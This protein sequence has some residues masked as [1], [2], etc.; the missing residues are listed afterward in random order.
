MRYKTIKLFVGAAFLLVSCFV[1]EPFVPEFPVGEVEGYK[2]LYANDVDTSIEVEHAQPLQNP[3]KIYVFQHYL[4]VSEQLKGIHV[5]DN[6]NPVDPKNIA[7]LRVLGNTD[8]A[9]RGDVLYVNHISDLVALNIRD[10]N[11]IKE[12]SRVKQDAWAS[13]VPPGEGRYFECPDPA[14]G[15]IVGWVIETLNNPTCFR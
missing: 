9:I 6:S 2:P 5:Y 8:M 1:G 11:S 12:L 10:W 4:L 14:K 3:G 15:A 13:N 7:F